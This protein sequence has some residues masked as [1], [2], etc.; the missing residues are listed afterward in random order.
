MT[1]VSNRANINNCS[2]CLPI[3]QTCRGRPTD[4]RIMPGTSN[5][6]TTQPEISNPPPTK[7]AGSSD[8]GSSAS[9][10]AN[11]SGQIANTSEPTLITNPTQN[12]HVAGRLGVRASTTLL[13]FAAVS[14]ALSTCP[15]AAH[16][17]IAA[18]TYGTGDG[19]TGGVGGTSTG[20]P[21]LEQKRAPRS[22]RDPQWGQVAL[23]SGLGVSISRRLYHFRPGLLSSTC[24]VAH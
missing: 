15:A 17:G 12:A 22:N 2:G 23:S 6:S 1:I 14:G 9:A 3:R 19:I 20:L 8:C 21:Q 5:T 24:P 16:V 18:S 7:P 11:N 10:T 4:T 13:R